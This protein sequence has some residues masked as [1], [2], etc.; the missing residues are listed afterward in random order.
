ME[1]KYYFFAYLVVDHDGNSTFGSEYC[2]VEP[3][4]SNRKAYFPAHT[5]SQSV[6]EQGF[7]SCTI[8]SYSSITRDEFFFQQKIAQGSSSQPVNL[9]S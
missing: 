2:S 5:V 7:K 4:D 3:T 8:L 1:L 9:Q 6:C